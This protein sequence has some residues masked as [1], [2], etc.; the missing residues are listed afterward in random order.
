MCVVKAPKSLGLRR[1]TPPT[2]G[3]V[4]MFEILVFVAVV[5]ILA[6]IFPSVAE[7]IF[8]LFVGL[9]QLIIRPKPDQYQRDMVEIDAAMRRAV[10][11]SHEE[12]E[13]YRAVLIQREIESKKMRQDQEALELEMDLAHEKR[14]ADIRAQHNN[15]HSSY[16]PPTTLR[17]IK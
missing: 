10:A 6:F 8:V 9:L 5:A 2:P 16:T 15:D 12:H 4:E 13:D 1:S 3:A 14:M 17:A 11:R 7:I